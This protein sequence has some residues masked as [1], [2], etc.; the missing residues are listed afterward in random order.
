[1]TARHKI[2]AR[3]VKRDE[4]TTMV[5]MKVGVVERWLNLNLKVNKNTKER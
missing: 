3:R 2:P 5:E 4:R 1:M